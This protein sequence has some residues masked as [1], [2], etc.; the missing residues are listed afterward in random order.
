MNAVGHA[1]AHAR[2]SVWFEGGCSLML[3]LVCLPMAGWRHRRWCPSSPL[4]A[5]QRNNLPAGTAA[6]LAG[7]GRLCGSRS[8]CREGAAAVAAG[9]RHR[10]AGGQGVE[11]APLSP[12]PPLTAPGG[13]SSQPSPRHNHTPQPLHHQRMCCRRLLHRSPSVCVGLRNLRGLRPCI[14]RAARARGMAG[15]RWADHTSGR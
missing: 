8:C 3:P 10:H 6:G 13:G 15:L 14:R 1:A 2:S 11:R 7:S 9:E 5:G 12:P 4:S